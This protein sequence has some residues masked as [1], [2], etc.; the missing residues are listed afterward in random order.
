MIR[1]SSHFAPYLVL[2]LV[3][4]NIFRSIWRVIQVI[5]LFI[6]RLTFSIMFNFSGLLFF[7][8][9]FR[10]ALDS[11]RF[12]S[13]GSVLI[14]VWDNLYTSYDLLANKGFIDWRWGEFFPG[15]DLGCSDFFYCA[16]TPA[17]LLKKDFRTRRFKLITTLLNW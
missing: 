14:T 8:F 16:N 3:H 9:Y 6:Q 4:L 1:G 15:S 10:T 12:S 11:G 5:K 7:I 13:H 17:G 2:T